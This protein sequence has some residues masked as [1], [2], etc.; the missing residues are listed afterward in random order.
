MSSIISESNPSTE[1]GDEVKRLQ[2][3]VQQ[4]ER[5]NQILRTKH[6]PA[7]QDSQETNDNVLTTSVN[8]PKSFSYDNNASD[9]LFQRLQDNESINSV[10]D[11]LDILDVD[12]VPDDEESW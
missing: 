5:Q 4:L 9:A 10:V 7:Q 3:L 1:P 6:A 12:D 11:G 8:R 2:D